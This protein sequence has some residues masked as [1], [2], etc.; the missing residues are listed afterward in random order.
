MLMTRRKSHYDARALSF[1]ADF[2]AKKLRGGGAN[3]C[4][5]LLQQSATDGQK[6]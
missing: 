6:E 3:G 2:S 5:F 1:L 4:F